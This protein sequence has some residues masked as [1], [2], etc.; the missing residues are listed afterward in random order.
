MG[1]MI[2]VKPGVKNDLGY[3][4]GLNGIEGKWRAQGDDF[5]TFLRDFVSGLPQF[6][7]LSGA[8]STG[9]LGVV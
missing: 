6:D 1:Q 7:P 5:R 3:S 2:G 4:F 8:M 9:K